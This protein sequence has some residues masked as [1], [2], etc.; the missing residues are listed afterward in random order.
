MET[1][2]FGCENPE[3]I[4][5][6]HGGGLSWWNYKD[7]SAILSKKYHVVIPLLDGHAG[8]DSDF[9]TI[10][11]AAER[12]C[13]Y[14]H[15]KYGG[16]VFFIGGLSLGGQILAEMLSVEPHICCYAMI[17]S[18]PVIPMA[19][20]NLLISPMVNASYGLIQKRWFSKLQF[21]QL[22]MDPDLF[23]MYY[24]DTCKIKKE[25]MLAFLNSNSSYA[26]KDSFRNCRANVLIA[27][28]EKE[29]RQMKRSAVLMKQSLPG[30]TLHIVPKYHHGDLSINHP[31]KYV[32][33]LGSFVG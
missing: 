29:R 5:L 30:S 32:D 9:T 11:N 13:E 28:G 2:E 22:R 19:L 23:E 20:T 24:R 17:E 6:L 18:A 16:Q 26:L 7:V 14:I 31:E 1:A 21:K 12:L 15:Q 25:N 27:V 10:E 3:T 8:S 33:L 4:F